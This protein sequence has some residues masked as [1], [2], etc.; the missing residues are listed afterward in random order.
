MFF[1][2]FQIN[3]YFG[4][5]ICST[6]NDVSEFVATSFLLSK[7]IAWF[8]RFIEVFLKSVSSW[9]MKT[10]NISS[11]IAP[12]TTRRV[13]SGIMNNALSSGSLNPHIQYKQ[14]KISLRLLDFLRGSVKNHS[15]ALVFKALV[16]FNTLLLNLIQVRSNEFP[17]L[18]ARQT[19]D[20]MNRCL[21]TYVDLILGLL[22]A[23]LFDIISY[24]SIFYL[25]LALLLHVSK[26]M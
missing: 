15:V 16:H 18:R 17:G 5:S 21:R 12:S 2:E 6:D 4:L 8:C 13:C 10:E 11:M 24:Y 3:L 22:L 25:V 23:S 26:Y 1:S 19:W 7:M 14:S 9:R 20:Q